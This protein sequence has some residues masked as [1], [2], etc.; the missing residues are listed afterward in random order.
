[1]KAI[2]LLEEASAEPALAGDAQPSTLTNGLC[3]PRVW[4]VV[5]PSPA[6]QAG[7]AVG[8]LMSSSCSLGLPTGSS[9][10]GTISFKVAFAPLCHPRNKTPR[11]FGPQQL[12]R[13]Q[14]GSEEA[15]RCPS[16]HRDI[17]W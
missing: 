1:M 17:S 7:L 10:V 16:C 15:W 5:A 4:L 13:S 12:L 8:A 14:G 9:N 2:G 11:S 3:G 6:P